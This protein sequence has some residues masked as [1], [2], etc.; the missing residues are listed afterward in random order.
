MRAGAGRY[1]WTHPI[2]PA[3]MRVP[4]LTYHSNNI[5]GNDYA[6]NDHVALAADLRLIHR[7][8][9]HIVPLARVVEVLL[10]EAPASLV[11]DG[12]ALSFDDGSWFDWH[13]IDHPSCGPQRGF[14]GVL[15]DFVA[16][17]GA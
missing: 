1:P 16:E 6:G 17:T 13:D 5:S 4:V 15:R 10:G 9:L 11:E 8:G 3:S 12:V 14:A 2:R 7:S